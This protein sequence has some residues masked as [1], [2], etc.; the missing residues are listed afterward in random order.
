MPAPGTLAP[1]LL[2]IGDLPLYAE[3]LD[4]EVAAEPPPAWA[5]FRAEVRSCAAILFVTPEYDRSVPAPLK[6]AVDVGS[7]P[8]GQHAF[9][10]K[11]AAIASVSTGRMGAFGANHHLRQSLVFLGMPTMARPEL[12]LGDSEGLFDLAGRLRDPAMRTRLARYMQAL[13]DWTPVHVPAA[14]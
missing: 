2:E 5:R 9:L 7:A 12:Y 11:P 13:A 1:R 3:D 4:V 8:H 6:N 10:G 14:A